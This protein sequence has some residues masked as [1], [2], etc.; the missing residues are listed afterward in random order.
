MAINPLTYG[1]ALLRRI[2]GEGTGAGD[3][4]LPG[5]LVSLGVTLLFAAATFATAIV[6]A[7]RPDGGSA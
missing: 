1:V 5:A 4:A 2:L 6:L 7:R 3:T